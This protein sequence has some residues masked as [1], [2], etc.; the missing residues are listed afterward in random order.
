MSSD[1]AR[2]VRPVSS[3]SDRVPPHNLEAEQALLGSMFLSPEAVEIGLNKLSAEDFYRDAHRRI[4]RAI[5]HLYDHN[6]PIDQLSVADRLESAGSSSN[7]GASPI[8]WM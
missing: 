4:F 7:Q 6:V 3:L 5:H 2:S 1:A 8:S